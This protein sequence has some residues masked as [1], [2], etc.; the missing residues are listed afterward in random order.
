MLKDDQLQVFNTQLKYTSPE[1]IRAH[2]HDHVERYK[3]QIQP[4]G[5]K[6]W[7]RDNS[8]QGPL[9]GSSGES[10][11]FRPAYITHGRDRRLA[12]VSEIQASSAARRVGQLASEVTGTDHSLK[13]RYA[14]ICWIDKEFEA[15]ARAMHPITVLI[16]EI[17]DGVTEAIEGIQGD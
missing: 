11:T 5:E 1:A 16:E 14:F 13:P 17:D 7:D 9:S 6:D 4:L 12:R 15:T 10:A 8:A 3:N 2:V